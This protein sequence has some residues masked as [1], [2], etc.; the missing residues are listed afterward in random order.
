MA[1]ILG[2]AFVIALTGAMAPG[3]VVALVI[4]Q[5]LAQGFAAAMLI[6][7]GH[8]LLEALLVVGF[9]VGLS[10]ALSRPR[11][12][13]TASL[14]GGAVMLWMGWD[15]AS[16]AGGLSLSGA[17]ATA[18]SWYALVLA[19]AGVS[20]ANPYF[21]G[22]WATVGTGQVATLGLRSRADYA[23]FFV[24]HE[25]GDVAW[26][27]F[28]ALVL[29]GGKGWLN[30]SIYRGMIWV[31]GAIILLLGLFFIYY[32]LRFIF[33]ASQPAPAASPSAQP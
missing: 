24:G 21:T 12:R 33:R 22:W 28:L 16:H 11:V 4:G 10:R 17:G 31:C 1:R 26:Y 23:A 5:V 6:I 30:D 15:M 20:L 14:L 3:P 9:A 27:G 7:A 2:L 13:G 32:A 8:A 18:M 29:V 25:L 19:G